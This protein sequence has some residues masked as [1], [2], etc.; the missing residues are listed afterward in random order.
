MLESKKEKKKKLDCHL[1]CNLILTF[2]LSILCELE[3]TDLFVC[4]TK[5]TQVVPDIQEVI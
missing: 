2:I 1:N 5:D 3:V 4:Y